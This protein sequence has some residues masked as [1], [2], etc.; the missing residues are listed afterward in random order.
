[1]LIKLTT[2]DQLIFICKSLLLLNDDNNVATV[3]VVAEFVEI[4]LCN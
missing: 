4:K 3:A 1:M 2:R